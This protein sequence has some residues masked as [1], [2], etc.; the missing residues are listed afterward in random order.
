MSSGDRLIARLGLLS[1]VCCLI[2]AVPAVALATDPVYEV[3][4]WVDDTPGKSLLLVNVT[5][6]ED[7]ELPASVV[8]PF[9]AEAEIVWAGEIR[10]PDPSMDVERSFVETELAGG[11]ALVMTLEDSRVAQYEADYR[12]TEVDGETRAST[13]EWTQSA[14]AEALWVAVQLPPGAEE[15][16]IDPPTTGETLTNEVGQTLHVY[17]PIEPLPDETIQVRVEYVQGEAPGFGVAAE[18]ADSR[19]NLIVG[20]VLVTVVGVALVVFLVRRSRRTHGAHDDHVPGA[21][22]EVDDEV[23]DG[24]Y[25]ADSERDAPA[26]D[27]APG[28]AGDGEDADDGFAF[29]VDDAWGEEDE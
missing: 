14:P 24:T 17:E 4:L 23:D 15:I 22:D 21:D 11:R 9:P 26:D 6:P 1:L 29:D 3:Q 27:A 12:E 16:A 2:V 19:T 7:V 25:H 10:G 13:M 28:E 8:I 18:G 20:L 5:I